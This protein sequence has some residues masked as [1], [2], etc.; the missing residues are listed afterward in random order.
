MTEGCGQ[1][2]KKRRQTQDCGGQL[3]TPAIASDHSYRHFPTPAQGVEATQ[4]NSRRHKL[5]R[6]VNHSDNFSRNKNF[7]LI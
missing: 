5:K 4:C 3:R 1:A 6:V 7:S 2:Q